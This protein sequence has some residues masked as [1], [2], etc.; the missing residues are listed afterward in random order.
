MLL[1][2]ALQ[3]Q[4]QNIDHTFIFVEYNLHDIIAF[5]TVND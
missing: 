4:K 1:L 5:I 3:L 2:L